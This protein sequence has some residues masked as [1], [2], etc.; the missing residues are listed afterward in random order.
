MCGSIII[1]VV[2]MEVARAHLAN[3]PWYTPSVLSSKTLYQIPETTTLW[4]VGG[5]SYIGTCIAYSLASDWR[6]P[7]YYNIGLLVMVTYSLIIYHIVFWMYPGWDNSS[8]YAFFELVTLPMYTRGILFMLAWLVLL[9]QVAFEALIVIKLGDYLRDKYGFGRYAQSQQVD[10]E[11]QMENRG[12][13]V[14]IV[15]NDTDQKDKDKDKE[16]SSSSDS[17]RTKNPILATKEDYDE[18]VSSLGDDN[19]NT[20]YNLLSS[21]DGRIPKDKDKE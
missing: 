15:G 21:K 5:F 12:D 13:T 7:I 9:L 8:F 10:L 2:M 16:E 20:S 3:Q 11:F 4:L 6:K 18:H 1:A 17:G 14:I 19:N